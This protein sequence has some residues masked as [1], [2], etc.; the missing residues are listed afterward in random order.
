MTTGSARQDSA[1]GIAHD[2]DHLWMTGK[3][4]FYATAQKE[5]NIPEGSLV[6]RA[7][8]DTIYVRVIWLIISALRRAHGLD[9]LDLVHKRSR[10]ESHHITTAT[11]PKMFNPLK[12]VTRKTYA[13]K[14]FENW[15]AH[16]KK[17][18]G[19]T[20]ER[21]RLPQELVDIIISYVYDAETLRSLSMT[22]RWCYFTAILYLHSSIT[23]YNLRDPLECLKKEGTWYAGRKQWPEPLQG[24]HRFDFLQLVMRISI[25]DKGL[26]GNYFTPEKLEGRTLLYFSALK[27]LQELRIDS[28]RLYSFVPNTEQHF[29]HF[30][31]TLQTLALERPAGTWR[32]IVYFIGHFPNL[33]NLK[34]CQFYV[35]SENA[36]SL[37]LVPPNNPPLR[38]WLT[39]EDVKGQGFVDAMV[40]LY[41][42]LR[43][44][45][46]SLRRVESMQ[47]VL[48][49]CANTLETL[50]LCTPGQN[51]ENR[52]FWMEDPELILIRGKLSRDR[53][54]E[55]NSTT[56]QV[57]SDT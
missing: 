5:E 37:A 15:E 19:F 39:L 50:Q 32:Q 36:A 13:Q 35:I 42:G 9:Q 48:D 1:R 22:C 30:A 7:T 29:G 49:A 31:P 55:I 45:C 10:E 4:V 54:V 23:T 8:C 53:R 38:G 27:N 21:P 18:Q 17:T 11:L 44:R 14:L 20:T 40:K 41:G 26:V 28:L 57:S 12:K 52:P 24:L 43:F 47:R 16:V 34:L 46:V 25:L 56:A 6:V 51:G 2:R 33:Q 3:P